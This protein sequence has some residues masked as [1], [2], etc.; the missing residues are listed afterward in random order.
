VAE[1]SRAAVDVA[2]E[3]DTESP[4]Q[5]TDGGA[6]AGTDP[7]T[8]V[9]T[10]EDT[11]DGDT[12]DEDTEDEDPDDDGES[13]ATLSAKEIAAELDADD[14][15]PLTRKRAAADKRNPASSRTPTPSGRPSPE[16]RATP[17]EPRPAAPTEHVEDGAG[18]EG[19]SAP[20]QDIAPPALHSGH[21]LA[22]RYRL[23]ECLGQGASFSSWRAVDEKLRRAVGIQ[24][25]SAAHQRAEAAIAAARSAALLPDPRFVHVLD[26]V[27]EGEVVYIV[28]EWLP[29]GTD[30]QTTLAAGPLEAYDAYQLI[31]KVAAAMAAAHQAGLVHLRLRPDAVLRTGGGQYRI[32]GL[33]VDAAVYGLDDPGLSLAE[34]RADDTR[35]LGALLYA[36]LSHHWPAAEGRHGLAGLPGGSTGLVAPDQVRAGVHRQL[37]QVA[38]R[39]LA[40][41]RH[42]EVPHQ[43]EVISTPQQLVDAIAELPKLRPPQQ[44]STYRSTGWSSYPAAAPSGNGTGKPP[45]ETPAPAGPPPALPGRTGRAV[46]TLVTLVVLIALGLGSWQMART[47]LA[48]DK[49]PGSGT[50][51]DHRP[52]KKSGD[53]KKPAAKP[54]RIAGAQEYT[55]G[56][57]PIRAD[58]V[59]LAIDGKPGTSWITS[60]YFRYP[61]F[62]NLRKQGSGIVVDL[63]SAKTVSGIKLTMYK[64]GQALEVLA[65]AP[66]TDSAQG[67]QNLDGYPQRLSQHGKARTDQSISLKKPVKTR[68]VL[69]HITA[70]PPEGGGFRGGISE[71]QVLGSN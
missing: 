59:P 12:A 4:A 27:R 54:L 69:V 30:L 3:R 31:R 24:I 48:D 1:R 23:E 13:T 5:H 47:M 51:A 49:D 66:G 38:M 65:A 67:P 19:D 62:G 63:G 42:E 55:A 61:E 28:R 32:R 35:A 7:E 57:A 58:G 33:A 60:M 64:P 25:L 21:K 53:G 9:S 70:L 16:L 56:A 36:A 2:A 18:P 52:G 34:Q 45:H 44:E 41:G 20:E 10:D 43:G 8:P 15:V 17:L 71:I 68:Y 37:A 40:A 22:D 26:A 50:G 29:D 11:A 6:A 39:A 14:D 46:K